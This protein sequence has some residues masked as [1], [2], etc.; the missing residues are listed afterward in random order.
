MSIFR[1]SGL[2]PEILRAVDEL[3]FEELM[4]VQEE[5]IPAIL[6]HDNDLIGLAQ[7]GT[8]KT[9]SFGLPLLHKMNEDIKNPQLVILT[10][11]R[12]LCMQIAKDFESFSKYMNNIHIVAVYGGASI[13][14]QIGSIRRGVHVVIATPGRLLDLIRRKCIDFRSISTVVLDEADEM[15][16][17]GFR[18]DIDTI[19]K[20]L[21][22]QRRTLMF[23]ATMSKDI[24]AIAANFMHEPLEI[25]IGKRNVGA[26]NVHHIYYVAS[27]H[28][29]YLVLRRVIDYFPDMYALIFCRTRE[30]TKKISEQLMKDGYNADALH[31]DLSQSQRDMAMQ[32]FRLKNTSFLVATDVAARGLDVTDLTHVINYNLPDEPDAYTHRSGRTGRA[33]KEGISICIVHSRELGKIRQIEKIVNKKIEKKLIPEGKEICE[34]QLFTFISKVENTISDFAPIEPYIPAINK[35]LDW[36]SKEDIIQRMVKMEFTRLLSSYEHAP[37]LNRTELLKNR[38][39]NGDKRRRNNENFTRFFIN[40]GEIDGLEK[41]Q[42]IGLIKDATGDRYIEIGRIDIMHKFSFFEC[43]SEETEKIL[44]AF[45]GRSN[46]GRRMIVDLAQPSER[47]ESSFPDRRERTGTK[48]KSFERKQSGKPERQNSRERNFYNKNKRK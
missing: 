44:K 32:K 21:P 38:T 5:V 30:E 26:E 1:Y 33:G 12:E 36:L 2:K 35:K 37:D 40:F 18:E 28:D 17:M 16:N 3:G 47:K 27:A 11:T 48:K 14:K 22:K 6:E 45:E 31:G 43:P 39:S 46:E 34:K 9:A 29:R 13:E 20:V 8:G 7:T 24:A 10:P 23:S 42:L 15:L 25:V 19:L 41:P 4:P